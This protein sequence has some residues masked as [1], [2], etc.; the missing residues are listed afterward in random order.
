[1]RERSSRYISVEILVAATLCAFLWLLY[2]L[3]VSNLHIVIPNG[4]GLLLSL[5]QVAVLL[6]AK[7]WLPDAVVA[8]LAPLFGVKEFPLKKTE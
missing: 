8:P 1:M 2:G 6:W 3:L 4:L 7:G 5:L